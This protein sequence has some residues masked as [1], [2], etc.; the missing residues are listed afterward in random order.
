MPALWIFGYGSL[1]FRP[2]FP[3]E[4]KRPAIVSGWMRRLEQGSPDHRGTPERLGRVA[5]LVPTPGGVVGGVVYRVANEHAEQV[6]AELDHR[7]KGGYDRITL[8]AEPL[9]GGPAL[10]AL[11]WIASP[12]NPY[13]L[14]PTPLPAM[15]E[16]IRDAVGPS[17]PNAQYVLRLTE[18][19]AELG[20]ADPYLDEVARS[21]RALLGSSATA[22]V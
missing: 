10:N 3:H 16:Q 19:L 12:G 5:T 11:T 18:A 4:E 6:L 2:G 20:I 7:E 15:V 17:G 21:L 9:G 1:I 13:H 8:A 22:S 14:G